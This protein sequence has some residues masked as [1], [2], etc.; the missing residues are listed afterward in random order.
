MP[1]AQDMPPHGGNVYAVA[2]RLGANPEDILDF[3]CNANI[4]AAH[5]TEEL[6]RKTP[7]PF[8]HYPDSDCARLREAVAAHE[9]LHPE[10]I[11]PGNGA[12]DL[13]WLAL[14]ALKPQKVVCLGPAFSE[15]AR[16]CA[17]L[18]AECSV[19]PTLPENDFACA[20][21][22]LRALR[23]SRADL[24]IVCS[25]NN[26]GGAA[27]QNLGLILGETRSP[28][29]LLDL[30]Y[31]DFLYGFPEHD[32]HAWAACSGF[33]QPG[34]RLLGLHSF[35]KFFCCPGLRLG[36]LAGD[37][38]LI[39]FLARQAPP[40]S[41][42]TLAQ[43]LGTRFLENIEA[44]RDTLP[45]LRAAQNLFGVNLRLSGAFD[46]DRVIEGPGFFC[47]GLNGVSGS[48]L[49]MEGAAARLREK[50]LARRILVRNCDNIPGMPP[51]YIRLQTRRE[52]DNEKL[53]KA[54]APT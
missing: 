43:E 45:A 21:D 4:F 7:Y 19:I 32:L 44:Y 40:W 34:T 42:M 24:V 11:L 27:Y 49:N 38:Q 53:L 2:M 30:S 20:S 1:P 3:S 22:E 52:K 39:K 10:Q 46:P 14:R 12:A 33:V 50:L 5:L 6:F 47:C 25:P 15:Y 16:A 36:Y 28:F 9:G 51:G 26:P 54:L 31:R 23:A 35:S 48:S 13:I 17:A 41:V 37:A 18:G 8:M 29:I